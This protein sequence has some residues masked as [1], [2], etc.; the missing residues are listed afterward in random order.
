MIPLDEELMIKVKEDGD[1]RAFQLLVQRHKKPILNFVYRF[2][3]DREVAEDLSQDVFLRLW[4]SSSTYLPLARFTTFLYTIAKNVCLNVLAKSKNAPLMQSLNDADVEAEVNF[5]N[6]PLCEALSNSSVSPEREVIGREIEDKVK[7]A[8]DKLSPE[9]RIVF[10]LT[11]Y[12]GLSY[13]EVAEI[14]QCPVGTVASRKNAAVKELR[15][16]LA[17]LKEI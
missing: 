11:Q 1:E 6:S 4:M 9:Q 14:A 13:Q 16:R 17:Y 3:G 5:S 15:H 8:V 7:E 12:H 10:I 2:L